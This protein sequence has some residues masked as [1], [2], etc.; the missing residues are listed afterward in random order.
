MEVRTSF[1][2][3]CA[4][5]FAAWLLTN[6]LG[7]ALTYLSYSVLM[8]G[9][10]GNAEATSLNPVAW[11]LTTFLAFS[12]VILPYS[13]GLIVAFYAALLW[14][15]LFFLPQLWALSAAQPL[16]RRGR[17]LL[18]ILTP[19]S[20][21]AAGQLAFRSHGLLVAT[22]CYCLACLLAIT[23]VFRRWVR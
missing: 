1:L 16:E 19:F 3:L 21:S 8:P 2:S 23:V 7:A 20:L 12:N 15:F 13:A 5:S 14:P 6:I 9:A 10:T 11:L 17:L 22:A 18:A 4:R